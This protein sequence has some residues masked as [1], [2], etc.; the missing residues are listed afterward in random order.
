MDDPN[1]RVV[2]PPPG[3]GNEEGEMMAVD[4]DIHME[5]GE[6]IEVQVVE[7]EDDGVDDHD[8]IDDE[9]FQQIQQASD[10]SG[11]SDDD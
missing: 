3:A 9:H 4:G 6:E 11:V 1:A 10:D 8:D 2:I 5:E 7:E